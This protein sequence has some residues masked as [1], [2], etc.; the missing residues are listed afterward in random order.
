MMMNHCG[1]DASLRL[2]EAGESV[3]SPNPKLGRNERLKRSS[4]AFTYPRAYNATA[5]HNETREYTKAN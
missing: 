4:A 3:L 1:S 2:S 5:T